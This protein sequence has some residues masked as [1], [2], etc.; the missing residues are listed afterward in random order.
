M[1]DQIIKVRENR[2]RRAAIRRGYYLTKSRRRDPLAVEF[3]TWRIRDA[4]HGNIVE[5]CDAI[6][7]AQVKK[8]IDGDYTLR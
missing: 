3:D 7:L 4:V 8:F 1:A 6:T 5:G 2:I